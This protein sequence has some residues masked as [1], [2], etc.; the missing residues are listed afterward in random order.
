[1]QYPFTH[2]THANAAEESRCLEA[3]ALIIT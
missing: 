2:H 1:M 3:A